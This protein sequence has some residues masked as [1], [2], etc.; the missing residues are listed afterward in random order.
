M[1]SFRIIVLFIIF[2]FLF[3]GVSDADLLQKAKKDIL[4]SQHKTEIKTS[5]DLFNKSSQNQTITNSCYN[6]CSQYSQ[7]SIQLHV[8][9]GPCEIIMDTLNSVNSFK[10][11]YKE[12]EVHYYMVPVKNSIDLTKFA[13]KLSSI[14]FEGEEEI[15]KE[16]PYFMF[17]DGVKSYKIAGLVDLEYAYREF[18]SSHQSIEKGIEGRHCKTIIPEV[19]FEEPSIDNEQIKQIQKRLK[20]VFYT[21]I[22]HGKLQ[23][24]KLKS[25]GSQYLPFNKFIAFSKEDL[26]WVS[27]EFKKGAWGCCIDCD[28]LIPQMQPCSKELLQ[29]LNVKSVP[30]IIELS[31]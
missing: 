21:S 22:P 8:W 3:S 30:T 16:V 24:Q 10:E 1:C 18:K 15:P 6:Q 27:E 11:K 13:E 9:V 14:K 5:K 23:I 20:E 26:E 19:K 25:E 4:S 7:S 29:K 31:P 28:K 12:V 17:T 2:A